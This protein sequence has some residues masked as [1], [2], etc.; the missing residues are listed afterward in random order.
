MPADKFFS[1]LGVGGNE[2]KEAKDTP[3]RSRKGEIG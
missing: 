1:R 2:A 3:S